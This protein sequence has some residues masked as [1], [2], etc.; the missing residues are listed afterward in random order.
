MLK[1]VERRLTLWPSSVVNNK[2]FKSRSRICHIN[3]NRISKDLKTWYSRNI[4]LTKITVSSSS[5]K[6]PR[7]RHHKWQ[8]VKQSEDQNS[9]LCLRAGVAGGS[10]KQCWP[11]VG[12]SNDAGSAPYS[13]MLPG[14]GRSIADWMPC[15]WRWCCSWYSTIPVSLRWRFSKSSS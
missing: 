10:R 11:S 9:V 14:D 12:N 15:G 4:L 5:P 13:A 1:R 3:N 7:W 2:C 8:T 6:K